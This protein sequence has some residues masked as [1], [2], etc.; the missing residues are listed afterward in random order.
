MSPADESVARSALATMKP[1]VLAGA[2]AVLVFFGGLGSWAAIAPLDSAAVAPAVLNVETRRKTVQHLEGGIVAEILVREG[3]PV[4]AGQPLLRLDGTQARANLQQLRIRQRALRALEARLVAERDGSEDVRFAD[5]GGDDALASVIADELQVFA[6]RRRALEGEEAILRNRITQFE[7]EIV[8]LNGQIAAQ[9]KQLDLIDEELAAQQKLFERKLTGMQRLIEL[10]RERAEI[11]GSRNQQIAAVARIRQRIA[12]EQ[13]RILELGTA[14]VNE[15][16][17][18]LREVRTSLSDLDERILAARDVLARTEITAPLDGVIVDLR[19]HT[20]GGVI[21]AGEPLLDIVP[22][23]ERLV[24]EARVDPIDIDAVSPGLRAQVVLSA[25]DRRTVA[26]VEGVV[27]SVSADRLT[28][29]RTGVPYYLAR[30]SLPDDALAGTGG[31][32]LSPGMQAEVM[33][34]TG[35][36]TALGY[37]VRPFVRSFRRALRE[38]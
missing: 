20:V 16:V 9:R 33:I 35:E 32:E 3:E 28:D 6:A 29:A 4:A 7:N 21:G 27:A 31:L 25:F 1:L 17:E 14:R 37:L 11:A 26:P 5:A 38:Q 10:K 18:Q 2:T 36:Q 23:G 22:E 34:L 30:I 15:V 12:E 8:G 13:L 24:A 19:V